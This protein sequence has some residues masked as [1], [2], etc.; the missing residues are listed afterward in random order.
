MNFSDRKFAQF[1]AE[2][3][4]INIDEKD[5]HAVIAAPRPLSGV[6]QRIADL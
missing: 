4:S 5:P 1:F 3:L 2:E 6:E